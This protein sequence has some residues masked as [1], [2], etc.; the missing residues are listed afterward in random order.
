MLWF[1]AKTGVFIAASYVQIYHQI[2][3]PP[4]LLLPPRIG[5]MFTT[6]V[7]VTVTLLVR[8]YHY[9][10]GMSTEKFDLLHA[11]PSCIIPNRTLLQSHA[12]A[13]PH[14]WCLTF[15]T[16]IYEFKGSTATGPLVYICR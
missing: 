16:A 12:L 6:Q 8:Y 3:F 5:G 1:T 2:H 10:G 14:S 15:F 11:G 7:G 9:I 4:W 13:L